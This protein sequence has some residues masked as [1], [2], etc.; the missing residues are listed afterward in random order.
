MLEGWV[1]GAEGGCQAGVLVVGVRER[2]GL[3]GRGFANPDG[4]VAVNPA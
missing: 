4:F 3:V 1:G 2:R